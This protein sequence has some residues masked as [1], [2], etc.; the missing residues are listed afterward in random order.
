MRAEKLPKNR[1][2]GLTVDSF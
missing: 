1:R 2:A